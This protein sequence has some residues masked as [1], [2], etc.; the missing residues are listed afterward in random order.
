MENDLH[1]VHFLTLAEIAELM[2]VSKRTVLRMIRSEKFP[3]FKVGSQWRISESQLIQWIEG[4]ES[5]QVHGTP[6][7]DAVSEDST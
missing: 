6:G 7:P 1:T 5:A 2:H 3:A 4:I